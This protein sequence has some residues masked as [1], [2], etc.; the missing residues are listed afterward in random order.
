MTWLMDDDQF[1]AAAASKMKANLMTPGPH[2]AM[3][4]GDS[5]F[6]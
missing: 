2:I 6:K 5:P 4:A 3:K 1:S